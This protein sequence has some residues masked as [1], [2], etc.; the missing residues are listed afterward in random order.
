[1]DYNWSKIDAR[2]SMQL[3]DITDPSARNISC[4]V[5]LAAN[6]S[7]ADKNELASFQLNAIVAGINT[8]T[9]SADQIKE[10]SNK[11][12][13]LRMSGSTRLYPAGQ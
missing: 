11:P 9:L 3:A 12:C 1:M 13:V 8:A 2:L 6:M 4:F 7:D 10:L 5:E